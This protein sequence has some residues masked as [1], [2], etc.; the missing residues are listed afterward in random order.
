VK[1]GRGHDPSLNK[2]EEPKPE[3]GLG[4]KKTKILPKKRKTAED[5]AGEQSAIIQK[6]A[7]KRQRSRDQKKRRPLPR[8][9]YHPTKTHEEKRKKKRL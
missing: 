6:I 5:L 9:K 3:V 8:K 1:K 4:K 7:V 2:A